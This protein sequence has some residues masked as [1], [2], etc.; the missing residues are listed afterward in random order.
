MEEQIVNTMLSQGAFGA[1]FVWLLF[2]TRKESKELLEST[3]LENKEREE[4]YQ[5]TITENQI[6]IT[7]QAEAFGVLSKDVSE[8]KQI[9]GKKGDD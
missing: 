1:L 4:R 2:S 8:I 9:L 6:V 7:K 3:R 5:Q